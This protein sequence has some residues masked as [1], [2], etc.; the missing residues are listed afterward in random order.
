M[1]GVGEYTEQEEEVIEVDKETALCCLFYRPSISRGWRAFI[2][3][4]FSFPCFTH[5]TAELT[6]TTEHKMFS[7]GTKVRNMGAWV[8]GS[9]E[10]LFTYLN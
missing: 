2:R 1:P 6:N 8:Q 7:T 10:T 5:T 9:G 4:E 3:F